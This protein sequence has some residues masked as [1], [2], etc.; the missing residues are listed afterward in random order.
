MKI[1]ANSEFTKKLVE[2]LGVEAWRRIVIDI[3]YDGVA[4]FYVEMLLDETKIK[5]IDMSA[6]ITFEPN[7]ES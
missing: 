4:T 3:H 5:E 7:E 2:A 1:N 6:G